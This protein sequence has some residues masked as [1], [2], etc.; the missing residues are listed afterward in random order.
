M[1]TG[2]KMNL[3]TFLFTCIFFPLGA[4]AAGGEGDPCAKVS[5]QMKA[6]CSKTA[7]DQKMAKQV[8][9]HCGEMAKKLPVYDK[10]M[11]TLSGECAK[12]GA[13]ASKSAGKRGRGAQGEANADTGAMMGESQ[14]LLG[15]CA[16]KTGAIE[17]D[18]QAMSASAGENLDKLEQT[19][20][21]SPECLDQA[22][23]AY[24]KLK[25]TADQRASDAKQKAEKY[26][27]AAK[28]MGAAGGDNKKNANDM[29]SMGDSS[30]GGGSGGGSPPGGG[31]GSPPQM[32][33]I[34]QLPQNKKDDKKQQD[35]VAAA[36]K[37][38]ARQTRI[39][40]CKATATAQCKATVTAAL[41]KAQQSCLS[42]GACTT[43]FPYLPEKPVASQLA[44]Q[45]DCQQKQDACKNQATTDSVTQTQACDATNPQTQACDATN[46]AGT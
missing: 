38:Q 22:K 15:D 2:L 43:Q 5:A 4:L 6:A 24:A 7:E 29:K 25:E 10:Q 14:N 8:S 30:K 3:S 40:Q 37:E 31:G 36:A 39:A 44:A 17:S 13:K 1:K 19:Q 26:A 28:G 46:P 41:G 33:Q 9:G 21:L 11:Q 42:Q 20:G 32:P 45:Q 18:Y 16:Q 23:K 34:P 35:A 27:G 12:S